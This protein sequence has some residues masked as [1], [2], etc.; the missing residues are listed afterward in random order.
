MKEFKGD[1]KQ[2]QLLLKVYQPRENYSDHFSFKSCRLAYSAESN[3]SGKIYRSRAELRETNVVFISTK[4]AANGKAPRY[5]YQEVLSTKIKKQADC[6]EF[7]IEKP[8]QPTALSK[9]QIRDLKKLPYVCL[10]DKFK[11][12]KR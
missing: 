5:D 9:I 10:S 11:T 1:Q 2:G 6:F 7:L 3:Y 4:D 8:E 12:T